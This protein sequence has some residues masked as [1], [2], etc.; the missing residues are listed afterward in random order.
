MDGDIDGALK[1]TQMYYPSVLDENPQIYFRLR[2]RKFVEMMRQSIPSPKTRVP[3]GAG[4]TM[5]PTT[6]DAFEQEDMDVDEPNGA[7]N[8]AIDEWDRM[9][10]EEA[11]DG[12][13]G[14]TKEASK[15]R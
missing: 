6:E 12:G 3:N 2:C 7:G 8:G 15:T 4:L 13:K 11:V 14:V 10:T 1:R 5:T 9:E